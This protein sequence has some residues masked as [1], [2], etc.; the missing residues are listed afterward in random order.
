MLPA[1]FTQRAGRDVRLWS[2]PQFQGLFSV[3][4]EGHLRVRVLQ[5]AV[6]GTCGWTLGRY[7]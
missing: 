1:L 6:S 2:L 3:P 5:A 4:A 7:K